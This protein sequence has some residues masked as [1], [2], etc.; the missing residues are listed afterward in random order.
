VSIISR[1][2]LTINAA[3]KYFFAELAFNISDD[4][5]EEDDYP[6]TIMYYFEVTQMSSS[7]SGW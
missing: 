6:G 7:S 5:R 3:W 2:G 4:C 1:D